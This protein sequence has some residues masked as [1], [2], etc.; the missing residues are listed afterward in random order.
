ML[1]GQTNM[2]RVGNVR[3]RSFLGE[4]RWP[5]GAAIS[6]SMILHFILVWGLSMHPE[7][8]SMIVTDLTFQDIEE[9]RQTNIPAYSAAPGLNF[10]P[11]PPEGAPASHQDPVSSAPETKKHVR[12]KARPKIHQEK[13]L[14]DIPRMA[15]A[16][17]PVQQIDAHSQDTEAIASSE[18]VSVLGAVESP[19]A[20]ASGSRP[21]IRGNPGGEAGGLFSG[22]ALQEAVPLYKNNPPP[23]YPAFAR[24]RGYQGTVILEALVNVDGTVADLR[25]SHSSGY[26]VLDQMALTSVKTWVFEPAKRG[27]EPV[28]M[29]VKIPICFQL[30]D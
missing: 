12:Q 23:E 15:S 20:A 4:T 3:R 7:S 21:S 2:H 6:V 14:A 10:Q 29:W 9:P 26:P 5:L 27:R 1:S 8:K 25:L 19:S 24:R 22:P 30:K 17:P 16:P 11:N 18:G 28:E 13:P